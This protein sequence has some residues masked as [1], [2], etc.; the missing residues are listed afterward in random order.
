MKL[1]R[2]R[3]Y[4]DAD[5]LGLAHVLIR[6]R[7]DVTF[8][9]DDGQRHRKSWTMSPCPIQETATPDDVWIPRV[10]A[11]G[12]AIITRDRHIEMRTAEKNAVLAARARM[13]AITAEESLDAWG[14]LE[15]VVTQ[16][17]HMEEAAEKPGPYIY[18]VTRSG[19]REIA[20][21]S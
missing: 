18:A 17:R 9:G 3:W 1:V 6:V 15:V 14:L 11:A 16:W 20:L 19:I 8:C 5:T 21:T 7:R 2:P 13:F 10:A 12:L 4:V